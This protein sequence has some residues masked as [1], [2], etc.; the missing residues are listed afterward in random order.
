MT[1]DPDGFGWIRMDLDGFEWIRM[2]G[3]NHHDRVI[4][5]R[6]GTC[7]SSLLNVGSRCV[8]G[9]EVLWIRV[10]GSLA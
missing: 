10:G 4:G 6:R 5:I 3:Q 2:D 7:E 8:S 1:E 9:Q